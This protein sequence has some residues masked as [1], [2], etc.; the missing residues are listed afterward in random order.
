MVTMAVFTMFTEYNQVKYTQAG[1]GET[2]D[3]GRGHATHELS[4]VL[5]VA[6]KITANGKEWITPAARLF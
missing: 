2:E 5:L 1:R 4:C 3:R 6:S